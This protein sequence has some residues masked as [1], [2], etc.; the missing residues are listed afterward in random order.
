[1]TAAPKNLHVPESKIVGC[2]QKLQK[3]DELITIISRL[4]SN[5]GNK[6]TCANIMKSPSVLHWS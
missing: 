2:I 5:L 3:L 1:M 4:Q 6:A